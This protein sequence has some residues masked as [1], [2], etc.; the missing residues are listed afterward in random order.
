MAVFTKEKVRTPS[1]IG[2]IGVVITDMAGGGETIDYS[3]QVFDIDG[4]IFK[5]KTGDLASHLSP[6][7][8]STIQAFMANIRTKAEK[9]LP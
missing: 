8:I 6:G 1:A 5:V 4:T 9:L 7:Q 2:D 3:I